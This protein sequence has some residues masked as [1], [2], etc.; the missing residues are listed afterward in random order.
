MPSELR[1]FLDTSVLFAAV[2]SETGGARLILK[3]GE[4][5]VLRLLVG[6]RVLQEADG[7]LARK[8]P[9][10]KGLFALLLDQAGVEVG[11]APNVAS[12]D[13]AERIM[14]YAPDARILAEALAA[15]VNYFV[16]FDRRHFIDNP[17]I[18]DVPFPVG[19]PEEFLAWLR[20]RL[21]RLESGE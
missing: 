15:Q 12:R 8:A 18:L 11:P 21:R 5:G 10:S 1:V 16:T 4:A 2:L 19:I 7:V 13:R 20:E 9:E 6:P 14:D 3:L 17:S